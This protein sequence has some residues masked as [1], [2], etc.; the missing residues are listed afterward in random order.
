M[1]SAVIVFYYLAL[2][3]QT[4]AFNLYPDVDPT[5]LGVVLGIS[6]DCLQAL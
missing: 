2:Q 3:Q 5:L 1:F 4:T 6:D